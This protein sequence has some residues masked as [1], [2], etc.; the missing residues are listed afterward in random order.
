[1]VCP[2]RHLGRT[3]GVGEEGKGGTSR[4]V[5]D[6]L[7]GWQEKEA[8]AKPRHITELPEAGKGTEVGWDGEGGVGWLGAR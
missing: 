7:W 1:M 8:T 3:L 4:T 5:L 2:E 6:L